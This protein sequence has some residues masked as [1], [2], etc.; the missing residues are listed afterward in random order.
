MSEVWAPSWTTC[1]KEHQAPDLYFAIGNEDDYRGRQLSFN[2]VCVL[3][4]ARDRSAE[5]TS[6]GK[7]AAE[8][9]A[10]ILQALVRVHRERLWSYPFGQMSIDAI[11]YLVVTGLFKPGP[12]H[13]NPASPL[14][15]NG[16]WNTF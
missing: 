7:K 4:I 12:R 2:S 8:A 11:N 13:Q 15:L 16:I 9:L 14:I 1:E 5:F 10:Q 3:A 6:H